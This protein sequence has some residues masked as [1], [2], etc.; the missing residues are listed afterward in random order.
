MAKNLYNLTAV[1]TVN[2]SDLLHVNQGSVS[3]DKK[4]TKQNL[5]KEVNSSITSINNSLPKSYD[6][7]ILS[8]ITIA[9]NREASID[10]PSSLIGKEI[11]SI[12]ILSW[13]SASGVFFIA[14]MYD[15]SPQFFIGGDP[16]TVIRG[17]NLRIWYKG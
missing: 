7:G 9:S 12:N 14:G 5:L 3:S 8:D 15:A 6:T 10:K 16:G 1:T 4:V 17:L 11:I 13:S 2:D